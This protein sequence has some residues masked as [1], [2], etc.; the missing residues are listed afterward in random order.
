[1]PTLFNWGGRK[2]AA[3]SGPPVPSAVSEPEP[4]TA[5]KVLPKV[6][7]AL[8]QQPAPVLMDLGPVVGANIGF[9]GEHL[10]C[11][12]HVEDLF[13]E[14]ERHAKAGTRDQLPTA[15]PNKLAR[16]AASIDGILCWD[17]FDYLDKKSGPALAAKLVEL[18]KPGGVI[19][20]FFGQSSGTLTTYTRFIV[21]SKAGFRLRSVPATPVAR[22]VFVNRDLG[23]M[24]AGMNVAESVLLKNSARETLFR[25]PS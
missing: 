13:A 4:V 9:F 12:I 14:V 6:L 5:S 8:G 16:E 17:L 15:L 20:G 22:S 25:K 7:S 21:D 23:K 24:F 11:K 10:S 2:D 1:V 3:A 19:Y 18:V